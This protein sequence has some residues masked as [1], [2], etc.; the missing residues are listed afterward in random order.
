MFQP[1]FPHV[2][3]ACGDPL[4]LSPAEVAPYLKDAKL[5]ADLKATVHK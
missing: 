3:A 5:A 4:T 2:I 1:D